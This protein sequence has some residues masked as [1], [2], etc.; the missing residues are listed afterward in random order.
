[1]SPEVCE[2]KP[3]SFQSDIW[4]VGTWAR[5]HERSLLLLLLSPHSHWF[6]IVRCSSAGCVLYEL[7]TLKHAFDSNNLL[8][9]VWKIVQESYP[10]IPS[11]YSVDLQ[12]L[13][14][15]MLA[16]DPLAR[17]T[18]EQMLDLKFI[19]RRLRVQIEEKLRARDG[20]AA[21]HHRRNRSSSTQSANTAAAASSSA[22]A[23][24]AADPSPSASRRHS[25]TADSMGN[26]FDNGMSVTVA[27]S[28]LHQHDDEISTTMSVQHSRY[29]DEPQSGD[30]NSNR[31]SPRPLVSG[32]GGGDSA[33]SEDLRAR[34]DTYLGQEHSYSRSAYPQSQSQSQSHSLQHSPSKGSGAG[35]PLPFS[36]SS[37][38]SPSNAKR[39]SLT[40]TIGAQ[41]IGKAL[42]VHPAASAA[43]SSSASA[44]GFSPKTLSPS[45]AQRHAQRGAGVGASPTNVG[46][47]ITRPRKCSNEDDG[48]ETQELVRS[49]RLPKHSELHP[50]GT[51]SL[52]AHNSGGGNGNPS[53]PLR[54]STA[55]PDTGDE[56]GFISQ[57]NSPSH[58]SGAD[59]S[60]VLLGGRS[61]TSSLRGVGARRQSEKL[62]SPPRPIAFGSPVGNPGATNGVVGRARAS[63]QL[64]S[65]S[66]RSAQSPSSRGG[67]ISPAR[68]SAT[69]EISSPR[70][71]GSFAKMKRGGP[72]D[73]AVV[74][75]SRTTVQLGSMADA[76]ARRAAAQRI[77]KQDSF[78]SVGGSDSEDETKPESEQ[79]Q[80]STPPQ[81][82]Q[83][84]PSPPQLQGPPSKPRVSAH[85]RSGHHRGASGSPAP[86]HSGDATP[87]RGTDDEEADASGGV[88]DEADLEEALAIEQLQSQLGEEGDSDDEDSQI[89]VLPSSD[90]DG[91][92]DNNEDGGEGESGSEEEDDEDEARSDADAD[93]EGDPQLPGLRATHRHDLHHQRMTVESFSAKRDP[94]LSSLSGTHGASGGSN[95]NSG[96]STLAAATSKK[97]HIHVTSA[98]GSAAAGAPSASSVDSGMLVLGGRHGLK[99]RGITAA[100]AGKSGA[101]G[102]GVTP[103]SPRS[104]LHQLLQPSLRSKFAAVKDRCLRSMSPAAFEAIYRHFQSRHMLSPRPSL[105]QGGGGGAGAGAGGGGG[106]GARNAFS[107]DSR[108]H[109]PAQTASSPAAGSGSAATP[110]SPSPSPSESEARNVRAVHDLLR[111]GGFAAEIPAVSAELIFRIEQLV[112]L[113]QVLDRPVGKPTLKS[114]DS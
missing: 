71:P 87:S 41:V 39:P 75:S 10:P 23:A 30:S 36:S 20:A 48:I 52:R 45:N 70:T 58:M 14:S 110:L 53:S 113:A 67:F 3:Y 109:S 100:A 21:A 114:A 32:I 96:A 37:L 82:Q 31:A 6:L 92:G 55:I 8:G 29:D 105:N 108:P 84:H 1:M 15:A 24:A 85:V 66:S 44:T 79:Q 81:Q 13:L 54:L 4:A 64:A 2:N 72:G 95:S 5:A 27:P 9:L 111:S 112:Y 49:V 91:E 26:V 7:C 99:H 33:C 43:S 51:G 34:D 93:E 86:L 68:D 35:N 94:A 19:K 62:I 97:L 76:K 78:E 102:S 98:S 12:E 107:Y 69:Y 25:E 61:A 11:M 103:P 56:E 89:Y 42:L 17:P 47:S 80:Q 73:G 60:M 38:A 59:T 106:S 18:V 63:T 101:G 65:P 83:Q 16:K 90:D 22:A 104:P 57:L 50:H 88:P 46:G 74:T 40:G 77:A 28:S